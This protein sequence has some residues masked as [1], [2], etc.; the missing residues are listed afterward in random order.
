MINT[1]L[2]NRM[3]AYIESTSDVERGSYK[4]YLIKARTP[5][6]ILNLKF[7]N[8]QNKSSFP[9]KGEF[10][11]LKITNLQKAVAELEKYKGLSLDSTNNKP[12]FCELETIE[13]EKISEEIRKIIKKDRSKQRIEVL[14]MIKDDSYWKNKKLHS[15]LMDFLKKEMNRFTEAP[16]A[17][18]NHHAYKGGL[19]IHTG[20]V[21]SICKGIVNSSKEEWI[22]SDVLYLAAWF[23]DVGKIEIYSIEE[24]VPKIN[25]DLEKKIGHA[26]ISNQIF[27]EIAKEHSLDKEF[28]NEV[29]H[30]ILSHHD[31]KEWGAL[32]EPDSIEAMVLCRADLISSKRPD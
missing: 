21:V 25:S 15:L 18:K 4:N 11:E 30:C 5:N 24:D 31:R 17:V 16:A 23:H 19:F 22:D 2:E 1:K 28:I 13:E 10:V 7:W 20:D 6:G 26:A 27:T 29:S 14:E 9:E 8:M 12:Y 32:V 3:V